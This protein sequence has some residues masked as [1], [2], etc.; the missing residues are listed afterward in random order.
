[1]SVLAERA[2][3][4]GVLA[5]VPVRTDSARTNLCQMPV[6]ATPMVAIAFVGGMALGV[7]IATA[8]GDVPTEQL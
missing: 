5:A 8:I 2:N 3:S 1:M 6:T 7:V 4:A